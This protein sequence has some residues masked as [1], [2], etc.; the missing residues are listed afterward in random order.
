MTKNS[1]KTKLKRLRKKL[2]ISQQEF[3]QRLGVNQA[4]ISRWENGLGVS[5]P[6]KVLLEKVVTGEIDLGAT[7]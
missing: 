6:T 3:A 7:K 2:G 4:Q 1:I 5:G